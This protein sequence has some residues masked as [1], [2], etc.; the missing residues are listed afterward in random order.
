MN[1]CAQGTGQ[2]RVGES[3]HMMHWG[4]GLKGR[5]VSVPSPKCVSGVPRDSIKDF[6]HCQEQPVVHNV[7]LFSK[8]KNTASETHTGQLAIPNKNKM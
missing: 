3:F 7:S 8:V 1:K 2:C 4:T 6:P 5:G